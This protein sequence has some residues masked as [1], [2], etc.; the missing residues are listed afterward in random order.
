METSAEKFE[1]Y[2]EIINEINARI[3]AINGDTGGYSILWSKLSHPCFNKLVE[4]GTKIIPYLIHKITHEGA[5]WTLLLLLHRISGEN[6]IPKEDSGSFIKAI[7]HWLTWYTESQYI[8][9]D[10]IYHGLITE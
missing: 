10:D 5:C 1:K 4:M 2:I 7:I 9:N 8:K 3:N 6:P